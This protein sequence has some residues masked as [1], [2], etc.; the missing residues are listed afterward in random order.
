MKLTKMFMG[1]LGALALTGCSSEEIAPD[2]KPIEGE[3]Q[4]RYMSITV[5]SVLP[6]TRAGNAGDQTDISGKPD[7][8]GKYEI[9]YGSENNIKTLRFYFFDD[10][11][12]PVVMNYEKSYYDCK[13]TDI[14]NAGTPDMDHTVEKILNAIIVIH[15]NDG[16]IA[17]KIKK[18]AAI[19]NFPGN[20]SL[21][22]NLSVAQLK[23]IVGNSEKIIDATSANGFAM[24]S[25]NYLGTGATGPS[26]TADIKPINVQT[27]VTL[28]KANPVDVYVERIASK[29]RVKAAWDN[30]VYSSGDIKTVTYKGMSYQAIPLYKKPKAGTTTK[31]HITATV[32]GAQK[33]IYVIFTGWN[34]WW[35]ADKSYLFKNIDGCNDTGLGDWWNSS[36]FKRS[37]WAINPSNV[38]LQNHVHKYADKTVLTTG[39]FE[40]DSDN[41]LTDIM[42]QNAYCLE[43]AADDATTTYLKSTYDP[44]TEKTNRTLVY[45]GGVLVTVDESNNASALELAE[46]AATREPKSNMKTRMFEVVQNQIY[47]RS[48]DAETATETDETDEGT[49]VTENKKYKMIAVTVDDVDFVSALTAD[50]A[51]EESENS[52]RY[53]SFLNMKDFKEGDNKGGTVISNKLYK[54]TSTGFNEITLEQANDILESVGG[55][56]VYTSGAVYYYHDITHLNTT[57]TEGTK[58]KYGVVRNH[59]YEVEL[60]TVYGLGTPVLHPEDDETSEDSEKIIPQKPANEYFLGARMNILAWRVVSNKADFDW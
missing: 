7:G 56:K 13:N 34:L 16:D 55:A 22:A 48:K 23:A 36:T 25:S 35:T 30:T 49:L 42:N 37:F 4:N 54:K 41:K 17:N 27:E 11:G 18:M 45:L 5:R 19:A 24:T 29:V 40:T 50:K 21:N 57:D 12:N 14:D 38:T 10:N 39:N 6:G 43:N 46:W 8:N 60:N 59:I 51:D 47:F 2:Q 9:G 31:E 28:A 44:L 32:D 53:Q 20:E 33:N 15:S 1:L 52:P 26:F 58:G 3:G